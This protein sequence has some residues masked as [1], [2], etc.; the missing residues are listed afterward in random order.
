MAGTATR[1]R[2]NLVRARHHKLKQQK[3]LFAKIQTAAIICL[4]V[5][6]L[7]LFAVVSLSALERNQQKKLETK[8]STEKQLLEDLR[9]VQI[10]QEL[11]KQKLDLIGEYYD[12]IRDARKL[13]LQ[14]FATMPEGVVLT[15]TT[16][17]ETE[18]TISL[19]GEA[20]DVYVMQNYL[21]VIDSLALNEGFEK[22]GFESINRSEDA[23]YHF[24]TS[25]QLADSEAIK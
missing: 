10:K 15:E 23:V 12:N 7:F 13:F 11:I 6:S 24:E 22:I 2:I 1:T 19:K 8:I 14:V 4:V 9:P 25:F 5:Y 18:S 21:A 17:G 3:I 16:W 20:S